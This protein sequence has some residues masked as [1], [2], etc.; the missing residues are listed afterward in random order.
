LWAELVL[1]SDLFDISCRDAARSEARTRGA[2]S[3]AQRGC[4]DQIE[5]DSAVRCRGGPPRGRDKA[6]VPGHVSRWRARACLTLER[7]VGQSARSV[8]L[9]QQSDQ[10]DHP[11]QRPTSGTGDSR[12]ARRRLDDA[13]NS[14][15]VRRSARSGCGPAAFLLSLRRTAL[16]VR[17][18][19]GTCSRT[20]QGVCRARAAPRPR[21]SR[22]PDPGRARR[23]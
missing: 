20:G 15:V 16:G 18:P 2:S 9:K 14:R 12:D 19:S 22:L 10:P 1:N 8:A 11:G 13:A 3:R 21:R 23:R 6:V 7:S 5:R 4:R 17:L